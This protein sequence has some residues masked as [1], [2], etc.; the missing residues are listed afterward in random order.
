MWWCFPGEYTVIRLVPKKLKQNNKWL[1]DLHHHNHYYH[2]PHKQQ[3]QQQQQQQQTFLLDTFSRSQ[4]VLLD[5][6]NYQVSV[7]KQEIPYLIQMD[8]WS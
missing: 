5:F 3:Q 1:I 8:K 2:H 4:L 7:L 6:I